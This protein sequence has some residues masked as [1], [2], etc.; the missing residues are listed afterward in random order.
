MK[1]YGREMAGVFSSTWDGAFPWRTLD[2]MLGAHLKKGG[3]WLDFA[4]GTG[5]LL[6]RANDEGFVCAGSDYSRAQLRFA[7]KAC[8]KATF[9]QGPMQSVKLPGKYDVITCF[10]DSIH[11]LQSRKELQQFFRKRKLIT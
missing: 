7:R 8:P 1:A 4:C 6:A 11:H 5:D 10:G 3:A 9:V 2:K